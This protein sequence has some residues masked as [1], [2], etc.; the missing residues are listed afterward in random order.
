MEFYLAPM[1]GITGYIYRNAHE[2]YFGTVDKYFSPF[3]APNQ[4]RC[5]NTREMQDVLPEHN[6]GME[7]VPQIL[8]NKAVDFL[9]TCEKLEGF[10][11]Q[12]VNLNLG[13]PS[14][15]VVS[16]KRGAGFLSDLALL[17]KFFDE[18]FKDVSVRVSVKTRIGMEQAEE[19][20]KLITLYNCYPIKELIIHPR[21]QKDFY[22]NVPDWEVFSEALT[23]CK[24]PICYNGDLFTKEHYKQFVDSF[25]NVEKVMLGRGVLV[26]PN[27]IGR[28]KDN[29]SLEKSML[30]EFHNQLLED[31]GQVLSGERN[32]LFKMKELWFY[33]HH[34]FTESE[35]YYKK[36][37]KAEKLSAY[38]TAVDALF[39]EQ[40]VKE[41]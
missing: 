9:K 24:M 39:R 10:G 38:K 23:R 32:L 15:T 13:C 7:L 28:I 4:N 14:G 25:P 6:K 41:P 29:K 30:Q 16:K 8:T 17:E 12:E 33:L 37:K 20:D 26:N 11:Y 19:F 36:I 21:V 34:A 27:L 31:Y 35:K 40:A 18:V 3:I 1:E 5:M 2:K 22:K